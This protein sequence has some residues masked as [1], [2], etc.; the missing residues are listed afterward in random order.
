MSQ[1]SRRFLASKEGDTLPAAA[2]HSGSRSENHKPKLVPSLQTAIKA[3]GDKFSLSTAMDKLKDTVSE[4]VD[5]HGAGFLDRTAKQITDMASNVVSWAKQ[6]PM[7][8][9][10]A[11]AALIAVSGV[12]FNLVHGKAKKV[13]K[14]VHAAKQV[15]AGIKTRVKNKVKALTRSRTATKRPKLAMV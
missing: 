13:A 15:K 2:D 4:Q 14:G 9:A 6:H 5:V 10:S 1:R 7:R 12:L 11:A 8:V 3:Q